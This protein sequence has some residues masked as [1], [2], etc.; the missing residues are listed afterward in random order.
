MKKLILLLFLIICLFVG[1]NSTYGEE[2][3]IG[4]I[5]GGNVG[6]RRC[7][8][9]DSSICP[10]DFDLNTGDEIYLTSTELFEGPGCTV[11]WY[12]G[13]FQGTEG[14]VCSSY[15]NIKTVIPV[16]NPA[17]FAEY[18]S[19]LT[20]LGFNEPGYVEKLAAL[21]ALH[22]NWQFVPVNTYINWNVAVNEESIS[23]KSCTYS[24][25]QGYYLTDSGKFDYLTNTFYS[26]DA[27]CYAANSNTVG[28][29]LDPRNWLTEK[30]I[31]MFEDLTYQPYQSVS[32]V[33][34]VLENNVN[35]KS[36]VNAF[37]SASS[38][39]ID[40]VT[41]TINPMHLASRSRVEIGNDPNVGGLR[42][43][44]N[45]PYLYRNNSLK[46]Y[47]N[48]F[49]IGSYADA[50]TTIASARGMGYAAGP[51][52]IGCGF[53]STYGRPW[54]SPEK[55]INGGAQF[56]IKKY[57]DNNQD[58]IY[59]Q[60]FNVVPKDGKTFANQYMQNIA[61]PVTE[62]A[63]NYYAYSDPN[64]LGLDQPIVFKIPVY[65]SMPVS[66]SLPNPGNPNNHLS[67]LTINGSTIAGFAHDNFL[68]DLNL[69][70]DVKS[71]NIGATNISSK[72]TVSGTG[73][74]SVNPTMTNIIIPVTAENG[75]VQEYNI[76]LSFTKV[77][78]INL[79]P[80]EIIEKSD[81]KSDGVYILGLLEGIT[82]NNVFESINKV[83]PTATIKFYN[84]S[85]QEKNGNLGTGDL[86]EIISGS[87][88]KQYP[89][90]ILGDG[91]GDGSVNL[92]DL[93]KVQKHILNV[94]P[95]TG[96]HLKALDV[97]YDSTID[98]KDLL[99]V[100]KYIL[101]YIKLD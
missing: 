52:C 38:Q 93:L 33:N 49:N 83:N 43:N 61:A 65:V 92:T 25:N 40:G 68:Y 76:R 73:N 81:L 69:L 58:T 50:Y 84:S 7:P 5:S 20:A 90:V 39:T 60:K 95:V 78:L 13:T 11:K 47:Y 66:T 12:K 101:G 48:F 30:N 96:S 27:G 100:Q 35:L 16:L 24:S 98:L 19:Y 21:H 99:K 4:V 94:N 37:H 46:G 51:N 45:Y 34:S 97:N 28:Y 91:N 67:N 6:F 14:Y 2:P 77:D 85:N 62:A 64:V 41:K 56:L 82:T 15:V 89:V 31:F 63:T 36:H 17:D 8:N 87:E 80:G 1:F 57:I 22:P 55:A 74:V 59:L 18:T 72:A 53:E 54:D 88:T 29:Y 32:A 9:S 23:G 75:A 71:I 86:V 3:I 79:K 70:D 44:G 42:V 26:I 10:R